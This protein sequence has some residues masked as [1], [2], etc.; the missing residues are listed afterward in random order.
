MNGDILGLFWGGCNPNLPLSSS[1]L[2]SSYFLVEERGRRFVSCR[3][4]DVGG[5]FVMQSLVIVSSSSSFV[6]T[7]SIGIE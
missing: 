5:L 3:V 1:F 7:N 2:S 4:V 6:W